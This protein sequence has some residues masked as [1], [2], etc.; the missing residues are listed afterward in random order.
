[1]FIVLLYTFYG[2][3][4]NAFIF[5]QDSEKSERLYEKELNLEPLI[6]YLCRLY[7]C[8]AIFIRR[9]KQSTGLDDYLRNPYL[10]TKKVPRTFLAT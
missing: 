1:M 10:P 8:F 4:S 5:F 7:D 9:L 3:L 6:L 2:K